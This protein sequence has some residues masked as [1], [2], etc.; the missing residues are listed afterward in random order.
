MELGREEQELLR[1][2][3]EA[4]EKLASDPQVEIEFGEP[5]CPHCGTFDPE[6]EIVIGVDVGVRGR[7]SEYVIIG[8]CATDGCG[9][10]FYGLTESY[11]MH[12]GMETLKPRLEER[13]E[14]AEQVRK[15]REE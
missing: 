8:K 14:G 15:G 7:L 9:Q 11:E 6:M 5:I 1:R 2:G 13:R 4:L 3:V 12:S 10:T